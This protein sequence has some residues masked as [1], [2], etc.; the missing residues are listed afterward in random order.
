M[1]RLFQKTGSFAGDYSGAAG[2]LQDMDGMLIFCDAGACMGGFLFGEDPKGGNEERNI[3]SASLREKQIVMGFD[4]K[5][6]KD[7][8]RT[9]RETGGVF[10]GLIGTPV[11]AVTGSDLEGLGKEISREIYKQGLTDRLIPALGIDTNGWDTY[12]AG[13]EK[14]YQALAKMLIREEE[15]NIGDVNII[16]ATSIDMW[17]Y[18][19]I[20]D[21]VKLL[22]QAGAKNPVVWG[23]R[24]SGKAISGAAGAKMNLA[25][26]VSA[27]KI[28][29][30]LHEKYGT[31]YMVGFPFGE[32]E[33]NRWVREVNAVLAGEKRKAEESVACPYRKNP[34]GKRAFIIG[35]QLT[36]CAMR[37]LLRNEFA[38]GQTDV[39]SFF[40]M[41]ESFMEERDFWIKDESTLERFLE[42]QE[43]YDL[44]IADPFC[45]QFLP[46]EPRKKIAYPH[47]AVSSLLYVG[48][49][50]NIFGEKASRYFKKM[51]KE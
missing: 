2:V 38:Y 1:A 7:A 11:A 8:I 49:S 29:K 28:V 51:L 45:F 47:I 39:A 12:D 17:D 22:K 32:R 30:K 13:Q 34:D 50:V 16:G 37:N 46:Y 42:E 9:Y 18:H 31:P 24:G 43:P 23:A 48:Q 10:I 20:D 36:S 15:E 35:E 4:R 40:K 14:A 6:K 25:V 5:L 19:Q 26:S 27:I 33:T 21:C 41:D 44:V 3:F